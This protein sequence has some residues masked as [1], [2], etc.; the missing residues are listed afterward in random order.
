MTERQITLT[1]RQQTIL[2]L[3]HYNGAY[4]SYRLDIEAAERLER[5]GLVRVVKGDGG[6]SPTEAVLTDSGKVAQ[7]DS[8]YSRIITVTS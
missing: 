1:K 2:N 3:A 7:Q 4:I 8:R 6:F 5:L